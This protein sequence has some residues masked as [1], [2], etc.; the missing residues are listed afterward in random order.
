[1]NLH[2]VS[3]EKGITEI[4]MEA[5]VSQK[6]ISLDDISVQY[7]VPHERIV[8]IKEY[9][10]RRLQRRV[11]YDLFMALDHINLTVYQGEVLGIIGQNG[12]GKS[13]LLKLI[14]KVLRPTEGRIWV[15]GRVAPLLELGSGFHPDL[16]GKENVYLYGSLLGFDRKSMEKQYEQIVDFAELWEFIDAPLRTYSSGMQA[17]LGFAVATDVRPDILIVDEILGVGDEGFQKKCAERIQSFRDQGASILVVS[18]SME[19]VQKMCQRAIWLD[20]GQIRFS[21][22]TR[23]AIA[24]YRQDQM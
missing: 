6:V 14:A 23:E 13:T 2:T 17:R 9:M 12:A 10:I 16:T 20:H 24:V 7:R 11:E 21:G 4:H 8:T 18:H 1:M 22:D 3:E 5:P 15:K 19:T